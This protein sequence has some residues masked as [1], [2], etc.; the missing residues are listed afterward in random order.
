MPAK[1]HVRLAIWSD[2][3][4][5]IIAWEPFFVCVAGLLLAIEF[6]ESIG[7]YFSVSVS[8]DLMPTFTVLL[9]AWIA[10]TSFN[11]FAWKTVL[12]RYDPFLTNVDGDQGGPYCACDRQCCCC[13]CVTSLESDD[14]SS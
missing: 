4:G 10:L 5:G 3:A 7:T 11:A 9:A 1:W 13:L 6:D 8:F 2:K 14:R 12:R